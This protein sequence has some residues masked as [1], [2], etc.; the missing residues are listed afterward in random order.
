MSYFVSLLNSN[1]LNIVKDMNSIDM[2]SSTVRVEIPFKHFLRSRFC[3]I[4]IL[5]SLG[6]LVIELLVF[7]YFYPYP[8]Y[9]NGDSYAYL[10]MA[11]TNPWI[12][13]Y[14]IGYPKFLRF[15]SIFSTSHVSLVVF[16]YL[17]IQLSALLLLLSSFYFFR[18]A[19]TI[20]VL[21]IMIV[22]LNPVILYLANYIS[23]DSI[24]L[25]LSISW[26]T[27]L[28]WIIH[29]PSLKLMLLHAGLIL[30]AFMVRYNALYFPVVS[31]VAIFLSREHFKVKLLGIVIAFCCIGTFVLFTSLEYKKLTGKAQFSPFSGWQMANN[32]LFG[33]AFVDSVN[34]KSLD[35]K[36]YQLD[37]LVRNYLDE[38][39]RQ[40]GGV[41]PQM[42]AL[43]AVY[44]WSPTSPLRIFMNQK[45]VG[46][47][48]VSELKRWADVAPLYHDY[49]VALI[50]SY[51]K[52]Y[53]ERYLWPNLIM[54]YVPPVEFLAAYGFN[55]DTVHRIEKVWFGYEKTK[56]NSRFKDVRVTVLD[57]YP[58]ISGTMNAVFLM[59][60]ISFLILKGRTLNIKLFQSLVLFSFFW[61]CNLLFSV[62]ASPIAL[63]FQVFP[64]VMCTVFNMILL[65]F[66]LKQ[67]KATPLVGA[68]VLSV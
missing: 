60:S 52:Q 37:T 5:C 13:T 26:F 34:R 17:A 47:T 50:R 46:D 56:L 67:N 42:Y 43:S 41:S 63:R 9:I 15:F 27:S 22:M 14:P 4:V 51:P 45:Y 10:K 7:K 65:D 53:C 29:R 8:A 36:F 55:M 44:M 35:P 38:S 1:Y 12:D 20:Q 64:L 2:D 33:Y 62:F 49:G 40:F 58:I 54:Y 16:Q 59:L 25:A 39:R 68:Q 11:Y 32:G 3:Q 19:K 57:Y 28:L 66:I 48:T 61:G 31:L 6:C 23:S 30:L 18:P 21:L 24:F